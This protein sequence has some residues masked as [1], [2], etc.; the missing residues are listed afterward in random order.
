MAL[1]ERGAAV[2][3]DDGVEILVPLGDV[4]VRT[5]ALAEDLHAH[6]DVEGVRFR[7][8][9]RVE[10]AG[11]SFVSLLLT[12]HALSGCVSIVSDEYSLKIRPI[13]P[14][15]VFVRM[16]PGCVEYVSRAPSF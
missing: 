16:S 3:G 14:A 4:D 12:L 11:T 7:G 13:P 6:V 10:I 5:R 8:E 15:S 1:D 9:L 2:L